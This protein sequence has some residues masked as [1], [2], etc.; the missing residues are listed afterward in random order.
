[1]SENPLAVVNNPEQALARV[2]KQKSALARL[3]ELKPATLELVS[4]S[5]KQEGAKPGQFRVTS[6]NQHFEDMRAVILF[7]PVEQRELYTKGE[8]TR[9][10]K[11]CFSLDN[12]MP[13]PAA[14]DPKAMYC[15]T[16]PFG[17]INWKKYREAKKAGVKGDELSKLVPPCRKY[18]HLFIAERTT[19]MPY[20]FNVKGTSVQ[21]F[22]GAMQNISRLMHGIV[23][24]INLENRKIAEANKAL[25]ADQQQPLIA[26]PSSVSDVIWKISFTMFV[27]Q[28]EKGGQYTLGMKDFAVMKPEDYAEFG[29][30]IENISAARAARKLQSQQESEAEGEAA[31]TAEADASTTEAPAENSVAAKNAQIKI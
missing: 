5:T 29:T 19:K 13:H 11:Q 8:Y 21:P 30:I 12:F 7:E 27:Q 23:N 4:K 1:M 20:Y 28:L 22:E 16:C 10:A 26:L 24:N 9:D 15:E 2:Q 31:A 25:A 3:F 14:K 6:T 17:D 18:W